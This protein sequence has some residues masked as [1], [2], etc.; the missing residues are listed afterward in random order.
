MAMSENGALGGLR[1]L[2]AHAAVAITITGTGDVRFAK[3]A[4]HINTVLRASAAS[5]SEP[6]RRQHSQVQR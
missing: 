3:A 2:C 5:R 4:D 6:A 1:F